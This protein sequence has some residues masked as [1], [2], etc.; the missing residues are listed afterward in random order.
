M[1][2]G[3]VNTPSTTSEIHASST[4]KISAARGGMTPVTIGR[5]RVRDMMRSMS[6]S[7]QQLMV[8]AAPAASMPPTNVAATRPV[9]GQ[10]PAASIIAGSVVTSNSST[11]FGLVRET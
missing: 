8:L 5:S 4:P 1:A 7:Y 3:V 10:P 11:S 9:P 2:S 6:R